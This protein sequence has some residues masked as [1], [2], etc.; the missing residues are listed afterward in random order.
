MTEP[1]AIIGIGCRFASVAG[2]DAFWRL[3]A[4]G[5]DAIAPPPP[6]RDVDGVPPGGYV[7]ELDTF[8][9]SFFKL[10]AREAAHID[11]QQRLVLEIG[12]EALEDAGSVPDELRGTRT[13][14]IVGV[15]TFDH[16]ALQLQRASTDAYVGTG[17]ALS[18]VAGRLAYTLDLRGPALSVDTAC[19][20]SLV[21]VHLACESLR[22]G[23]C[24]LA[25]A[26]GV[27]V[28]LAPTVTREF[29]RASLLA[30]D[31][32]CKPFDARADGYVRSEGAGLVV[33]KPLAEA[34]R[35]DD[36]IYAVIRGSAV[37]QDGRS[38]GLTAP[39]CAAQEAVLRAAYAAASVDPVDVDYVE[40]HG[41][42]TALGDPIEARALGAVVG[43]G[44]SPNRACAIGS[45][46]S[47]IGHTEAAAGIAGLIKATLALHHGEIPPS[48]HFEQPNPRI[49]FD[50]LALSV[51]RE[52]CPLGPRDRPALAGISAFG[53]SGTNAHVVIE[54][55]PDP[56]PADAAGGDEIV[57]VL[58]SARDQPALRAAAGAL[59]GHVL[60]EAP[61]LA[62]VARTTAL[63]RAQHPERLVLLAGGRDELAAGLEAFTAGAAWPSAVSGRAPRR[64]PRIA[65]VFPGQGGQWRG[66]GAALEQREPAFA[67]ASARART[68]ITAAS[69]AD[70][71]GGH[72]A[73]GGFGAPTLAQPALFALQIAL[74][75]LWRSWGV[76]PVATVGH[77]MG[78]VAAACVAG[79]L[80]LED[81]ARVI[82]LRSALLQRIAGRGQMLLV[83]L[84]ADS[85]LEVAGS[86]R[87]YL[88][89][90][91]GPTSSV[92]AG[93]PEEI[94]DAM[95][96]LRS[97]G[98]WCR[99][100]DVD[101]AAHGADVE[102]LLA[103]L[104]GGLR[105]LEARR[106]TLELYS[107]V[108]GE[109]WGDPL[110]A[111]YWEANL[112]R[113]VRF[114]PAA[115]RMLEDGIDAFVELS[116]HPTLVRALSSGV[117][118]VRADAVAVGGLRRDENAREGLLR[119]AAEL[120]VRGAI[121]DWERILPAARWVRLPPY[122]WQRASLPGHAGGAGDTWTGL[123]GTRVA[124]STA[125]G[126]HIWP[127]APATALMREHRIADVAVMP[128]A[129]YV[130][131][132]LAGARELGFATPELAGVAFKR[133][134]SLP[135]ESDPPTVQLAFQPD[136]EHWRF[137][138]ASLAGGAWATHAEGSAR[139]AQATPGDDVG[140]ARKHCTSPVSLD[141]HY[142]HLA[143]AGAT[144]GP[145]LRPLTEAW[146]GAGEAF[147]HLT[148]APALMSTSEVEAALLDGTLHVI[149]IAATARLT[150]R[151]SGP[152]VPT[153][154][155]RL[156]SVRPL[157]AGEAY[158]CHAVLE[159]AG[160]HR[161]QGS[162]RVY[163]DDGALSCRA[164][165]V[166][167]EWLQRRV[168]APRLHAV[169][170]T[171]AEPPARRATSR[172]VVGPGAA[173]AVLGTALGAPVTRDAQGLRHHGMTPTQIVYAVP[174]T[175]GLGAPGHAQQDL[176][177]LVQALPSSGVRL[178]A[179]THGVHALSGDGPMVCAPAA[180]V[181]GLLRAIANERPELGCRLVDL[182]ARP[183]AA[184][185]EL[186]GRVLDGEATETVI[187]GGRA[188]TPNLVA[189]P[190]IPS[191]AP[192]LRA[193]R[194]YVISG[195]T[196]A[197]GLLLAEHLST[198]GA[199][200][201]ALLARREPQPAQRAQLAIIDA[202]VTVLV[203]DVAAPGL[204]G[205]LERVRSPIA[206]VI[207]AAGRLDDGLAAD[208]T[209]ERLDAVMAP[210]ALGAWNLHE[211]LLG[212]ELDFFVL[213]SSIAG[214]LG[215]PA[216]ANHAAAS[217]YL[218]ALAA[219]R[220]GLGLPAL[221]IAWGPWRDLG[222][223]GAA[224]PRLERLGV[225]GL[226]REQGLAAFDAALMLGRTQVAVL[227]VDPAR[228]RVHAA[229]GATLLR[230]LAGPEPM[231]AESRLR[232]ELAALPP[233]ARR[234]RLRTLVLERLAAILRVEVG[235]IDPHA[236]LLD[237]GLDSLMGI[238]LRD[239]LQNRLD[240]PLPSG[241][242]WAHPT[243]AD[244]V[245]G[246]LARFEGHDPACGDIA[247]ELRVIEQ[248]LRS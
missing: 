93:P 77:S 169:T 10:S 127:V 60:R 205:V 226:D 236:P 190:A 136:G 118:A 128:A 175:G 165:G 59:H 231:V 243:V 122:Q 15:A 170:W 69:G 182:P 237:L 157:V 104:A 8:D 220:A 98:V 161:L 179:V 206:G 225:L 124:V 154:I 14:V 91:N 204:R 228:L 55:A 150:G 89:A 96:T 200:S 160:E 95:T 139:S 49:D 75:A 81:A 37:N 51:Q 28:L 61:T 227:A 247:A 130:A 143:A 248:E 233:T 115:R 229:N 1:I 185:L 147:A 221:S 213:F 198:L 113:P 218:D 100:I 216:Q 240:L 41:S 152:A 120:H 135:D 65:F 27:S 241:L 183:L 142:D 76:E 187:R 56:A 53:F 116:P 134:L 167:L 103:E 121:I 66:M 112:R 92:I 102:P 210:K 119:A 148:A 109:P 50:A 186:L 211:A 6:G 242:V 223:A 26:G 20:S 80:T 171:Q 87:I 107:T 12:W 45:V 239:E 194:T 114:W 193:D 19:S 86:A 146:C 94:E 212:V 234:S 47:N 57:P 159:R 101:V 39:N 145:A 42:G 17:G 62:G 105:G 202:D 36:R 141:E 88:A 191:A 35:D 33:L 85:A 207:H 46:K 90:A 74:A 149:G 235:A 125:P 79:A 83:E 67:A 64:A 108:T 29:A 22:R 140:A 117:A 63:R 238:E 84:P 97:A 166:T 30:A 106:P 173:A 214:L 58:L 11:P 32:R 34:L 246:L 3:L 153:R 5:V 52:L 99:R 133:P 68:A 38:N 131:A 73:D 44:R 25:L 144:F 232:D 178:S 245:D 155:E 217:A 174:G 132:A 176:L 172:V 195:G 162:I 54:G 203:A 163:G 177:E 181:W 189:L 2:P 215:S 21:A 137:M 156:S 184:D 126:T 197:L 72:R 4:D 16:G 201:I 230:S 110:D 82:T 244:L 111:G 208:L 78:E 40:A 196:G 9:H 164:D 13:A 31:G 71:G 180:P 192:S 219:Y 222:A 7:S 18:V 224:L 158:W 24:E 199:R 188:A 209:R 23:E 43:A 151:R 129:G 168:H 70:A 123:L 48:L 138:V